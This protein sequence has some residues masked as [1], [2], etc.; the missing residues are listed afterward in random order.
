MHET[1]RVGEMSVTFLK[2][3]HET[4]GKLDL[5]ELT[6]PAQ[7]H[8]YVPHFHRN[9]D[10]IAF[11]MNGVVTFTVEGKRIQIAHG[12]KLTI[13]RGKS[14]YF[15][16]HQKT[17]ARLMCLYTPGVMGPEYFREIAAYFDENGKPDVAGIGSVMLRY[18]VIPTN[19]EQQLTSLIV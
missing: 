19:R 14:H 10:E 13:P 5:F 9:Y 16:N 18:G 11:G 15:G 12:D 7:T 17:A 2:S 3:R 4:G 1:I 8:L 6:I